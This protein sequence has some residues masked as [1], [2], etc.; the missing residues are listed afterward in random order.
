MG[1]YEVAVKWWSDDDKR[2]IQ[3]LTLIPGEDFSDASARIEN[4]CGK[5]LV[6]FTIRELETPVVLDKEMLDYWDEQI[7]EENN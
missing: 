3:N 6:E 1:I 5:D 7:G 4:Y 2:V